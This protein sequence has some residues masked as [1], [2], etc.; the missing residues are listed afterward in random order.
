MELLF[1]RVRTPLSRV[2]DDPHKLVPR[3]FGSLNP[4]THTLVDPLSS[5]RWISEVHGRE[6]LPPGWTQPSLITDY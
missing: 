5:G 3:S 4:L 1:F 6:L 2:N